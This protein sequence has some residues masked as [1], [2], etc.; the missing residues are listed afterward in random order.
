ML[1][2]KKLQDVLGMVTGYLIRGKSKKY[3]RKHLT[4]C[5]RMR[6][7]FPLQNIVWTKKLSKVSSHC[8]VLW[9][10]LTKTMM[11]MRKT[12]ASQSIFCNYVAFGERVGWKKILVWKKM[13]CFIVWKYGTVA[14]SSEFWFWVGNCLIFEVHLGYSAVESQKVRRWE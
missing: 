1:A 14:I 13:S 11:N 5:W 3:S 8:C 10:T 12:G 6:F 2:T 7:H 4:M 9:K